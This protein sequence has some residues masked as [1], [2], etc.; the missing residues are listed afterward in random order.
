[1]LY[2]ERTLWG[3]GVLTYFG[4]DFCWIGGGM[5]GVMVGDGWSGVWCLL[6]PCGHGGPFAS[7][8]G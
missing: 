6:G 5:V 2:L 7:A 3:S 8:Q 4:V 1:M